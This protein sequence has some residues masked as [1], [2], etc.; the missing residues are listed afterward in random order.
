MVHEKTKYPIDSC[1]KTSLSDSDRTRL[2]SVNVLEY[3]FMHLRMFPSLYNWKVYYVF[4]MLH[5]LM[6]HIVK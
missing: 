2:H 4:Q 1:F 5:M 3:T 6:T